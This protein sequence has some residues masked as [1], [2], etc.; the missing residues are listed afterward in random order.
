MKKYL[1]NNNELINSLDYNFE[2]YWK[3]C[4]YL[5]IQYQEKSKFDK[6]SFIE[7]SSNIAYF[8]TSHMVNKIT[9]RLQRFLF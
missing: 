2:G 8:A 4:D 3:L 7:E 9:K 1:Q 6:F 5:A